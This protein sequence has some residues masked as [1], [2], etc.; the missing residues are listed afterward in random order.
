M[1]RVLDLM[2]EFIGPLHNWLQ[3]FTNHYLTHCHLLLTGHSTGTELNSLYS[4]VLLQFSLLC[5]LITPRH[6]SHGKHRLLLSRMHVYCP[7]RSNECRSTVQRLCH[8]K[9]FADSFPSNGC[10][11]HSIIPKWTWRDREK[12]RKPLSKFEPSTFRIEI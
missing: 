11:Y 1:R 10:T 5:P 7:L 8:G 6:G 4:P 12:L 9:V 3:Q 2:I